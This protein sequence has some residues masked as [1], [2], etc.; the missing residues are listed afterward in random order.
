[1]STLLDLSERFDVIERVQLQKLLNE[2]NMEASSPWRVAKPDSARRRLLLLGKVTNLRMKT[3]QKSAASG[4]ST[5]ADLRGAT[6]RR[7]T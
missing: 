4:C 5:S 3:E 7:R 1:M 2:Q 6:T